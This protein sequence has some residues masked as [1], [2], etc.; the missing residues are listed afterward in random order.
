MSCNKIVSFQ[1]EKERIELENCRYEG[2]VSIYIKGD[3]FE[4]AN[5]CY[6]LEYIEQEYLED[7]F[8][9]I[10]NSLAQELLQDSDRF[11]IQEPIEPLLN[12]EITIDYYSSTHNSNKFFFEHSPEDI[13]YTQLFVVL[14]SCVANLRQ[15]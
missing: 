3:S 5:Y 2:S 7:F 8:L 15:Q 9:T 1:K 6:F 14:N 11:K 4:N 13:T 12:T 10:L